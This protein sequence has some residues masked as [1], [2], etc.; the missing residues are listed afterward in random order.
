MHP[1][2]E[3]PV[4]EELSDST[5]NNNVLISTILLHN[6]TTSHNIINKKLTS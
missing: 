5:T 3:V 6:Y 1:P 4:M 2:D